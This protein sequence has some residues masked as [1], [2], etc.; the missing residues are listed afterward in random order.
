MA[1]RPKEKINVAIQYPEDQGASISRLIIF[2]DSL[3]DTGNMK[4]RLRVFQQRPTG[5]VDFPTA[6]LGLTISGH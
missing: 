5:L 2:G 3:S 1:F 4:A 6:L